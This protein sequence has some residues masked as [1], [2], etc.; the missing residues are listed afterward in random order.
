[1]ASTAIPGSVFTR[2]Q[3]HLICR[4]PP[5][6]LQ[7]FGGYKDFVLDNLKIG[8]IESQTRTK[9]EAQDKGQGNPRQVRFQAC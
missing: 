6:I 5:A 9:A 3:P 8:R 4:V 2:P 1:M 7:D